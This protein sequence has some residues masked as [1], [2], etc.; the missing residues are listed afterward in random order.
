MTKS[1]LAD[2]SSS[3]VKTRTAAGNRTKLILGVGSGQALS[4]RTNNLKYHLMRDL[5]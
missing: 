3:E 4:M 1:H 5:L 2:F